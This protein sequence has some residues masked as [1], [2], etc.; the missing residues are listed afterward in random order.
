MS[1]RHLPSRPRAVPCRAPGFSL[2]LLAIAAAHSAFPAQPAPAFDLASAPT[3]MVREYLM[4]TIAELRLYDRQDPARLRAALD[5]ARA[6]LH[7]IDHLMAVQRSDSDVSRLNAR[8]GG[9]PVAV[10]ARLVELLDAARAVSELTGG[11]FDVTVLP[12]VEAWGFTASAP[13]V[14]AVT[15]RIA[16][17]RHVRLDAASATVTLTAPGARLDLG[18]I[19]KGYALDRVLAILRAHGV[20]S[21]YLDLGGEVA[22]IGLPPDDAC[23]R[24]GIRHPRRPGT[25]VGVLDVAEGAVSTSGDAEQ[26][27]LAD[28]ARFGHIF[29]PRTGVPARGLVSATVVA[30]SATLA[31]ALST[32]AV[33]LGRTAAGV[34][35]DRVAAAGVLVDLR[36]DGELAVT[37]SGSVA[38][39]R[40]P[41]DGE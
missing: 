26:F 33:V 7:T 36:N 14:P 32:A 9:A 5:A 39:R 24:I 19:A 38:F 13:R 15:P 37:T 2:T 8:G 16:G 12:A 23:W 40:L 27:V 4:G 6:E 31:D 3:V 11:A 28:G 25:I 20:R 22:T 17:F 35:L 18:G 41:D 29:D 34:A 30:A 1:P 21:A 10:D